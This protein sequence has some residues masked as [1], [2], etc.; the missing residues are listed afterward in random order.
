MCRA[1]TRRAAF[2]L[3]G[4][5]RFNALRTSD[6]GWHYSQKMKSVVSLVCLDGRQTD[7]QTEQLPPRKKVL[8]R[9]SKVLRGF[10][11]RF[12]LVAVTL[13]FMQIPCTNLIETG[14]GGGW[15]WQLISSDHIAD[16]IQISRRREIRIPV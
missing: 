6:L 5:L 14:K 8:T 9:T 15:H 13:Y 3:Q 16:S 2:V 4:G 1:D 12:F 10:L 11:V 7:R